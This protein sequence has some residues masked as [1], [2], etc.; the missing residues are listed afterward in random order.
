MRSVHKFYNA[1]RAWLDLFDLHEFRTLLTEI[2]VPV[3]LVSSLTCMILGLLV[4]FG[5]QGLFA[6]LLFVV[7]FVLMLSIGGTL[8]ENWTQ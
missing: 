1:L 8:L 5:I 3:R 6:I 7:A 2:S 4:A